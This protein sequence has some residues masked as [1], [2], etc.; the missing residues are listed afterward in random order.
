MDN[1]VA[2]SAQFGKW[3]IGCDVPLASNHPGAVGFLKKEATKADCWSARMDGKYVKEG[4]GTGPCYDLETA[5]QQCEDATDCFAIATQSNVC[6]GQFRVTHG[7]PTFMTYSNWQPYDLH[8]YQLDRSCV[9]VPTD[10]P[11]PV[12]I[13]TKAD[14][15]SARM[16]GKYVNEGHGTGPCYDLETAKQQCEDA[17]D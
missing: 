1:C 15:W 2:Y 13:A 8:A 14:C 6:S 11:T 12:P 17:S 10:A 9:S 16:D 5:K 3:C 7:G 4:H